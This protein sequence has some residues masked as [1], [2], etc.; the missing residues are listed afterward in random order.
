MIQRYNSKP[1]HYL[2]SWHPCLRPCHAA[3]VSG[4]HHLGISQAMKSSNHHFSG[5]KCPVSLR[6]SILSNENPRVGIPEMIE[7]WCRHQK[8]LDQEYRGNSWRQSER[9]KKMQTNWNTGRAFLNILN[10][11]ESDGPRSHAEIVQKKLVKTKTST[12]V[13]T[14]ACHILE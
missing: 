4:T 14:N 9:I 3:V 13:G 11:N 10:I 12:M 7:L 5:A 2:P 8:T 1:W 6:E